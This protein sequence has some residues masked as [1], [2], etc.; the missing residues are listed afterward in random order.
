MTC[1]FLQKPTP[2]MD[3]E[4]VARQICTSVIIPWILYRR[5]DAGRENLQQFLFTSKINNFKFN[6]I[7]ENLRAV[8]DVWIIEDHLVRMAYPYLQQLEVDHKKGGCNYLH[9]NYD[10]YAYYPSFTDRNTL[11][12]IR[13][14]LIEGLNRRQKIA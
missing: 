12:M 8:K 5:K 10:T 11:S 9:E 4:L 6:E 2:S 14:S 7:A 3:G 1:V 13:T